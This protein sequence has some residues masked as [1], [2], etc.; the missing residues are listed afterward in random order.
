VGAKSLLMGDKIPPLI[1]FAKGLLYSF[2]GDSFA[3]LC[4]L[5]VL[6]FIPIFV[7]KLIKGENY[8]DC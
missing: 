2:I 7:F 1:V 6:V 3:L 5:S 4:L 8:Y